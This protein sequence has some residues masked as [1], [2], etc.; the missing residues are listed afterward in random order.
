MAVA[1]TIGLPIALRQ[2]LTA[3]QQYHL[4]QRTYDLAQKTYGLNVGS[5]R[6]EY[7][8]HQIEYA[9]VVNQ[10]VVSP[11]GKTAYGPDNMIITIPGT[12]PTDIEVHRTR[13]RALHEFGGQNSKLSYSW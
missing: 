9:H 13:K 12:H 8:K 6:I 1:A 7:A 5:Q 11:D 10:G 4:A 2:C 3:S